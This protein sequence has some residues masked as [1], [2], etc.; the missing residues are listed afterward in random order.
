MDK[1]KAKVPTNPA[2]WGFVKKRARASSKG[3][4]P[5]RWS[6]QKAV[7]AQKQYEKRGGGWKNVPIPA[8]KKPSGAKK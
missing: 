6:A 7:L 2:L 1:S 5:G 8:G 4:E 3:G